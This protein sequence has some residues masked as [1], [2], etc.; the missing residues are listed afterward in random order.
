MNKGSFIKNK[1]GNKFRTSS[2]FAQ[3]ELY[4]FIFNY[5]KLLYK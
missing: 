1:N 4:M 2:G 5:I 3:S